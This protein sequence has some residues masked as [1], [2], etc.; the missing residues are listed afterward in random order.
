MADDNFSDAP[1]SLSIA[2]GIRE[3]N[4]SLVKPRDILVEMLRDIDNGVDVEL[5]VISFRFGGEAVGRGKASFM[6]AGGVGL[7][8]SLGLLERVKHQLN[9]FADE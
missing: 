9:E 6:Q 1:E 7:H 5:M 8:D 3:S 4:A 2:R